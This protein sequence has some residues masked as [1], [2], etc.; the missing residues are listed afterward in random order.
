MHRTLLLICIVLTSGTSFSQSEIPRYTLSAAVLGTREVPDLFWLDLT[1]DEDGNPNPEYKQLDIGMGNRG[2]KIEV[3]ALPP[4]ALYRRSTSESGELEFT[5]AIT[6]PEQDPDDHLLVLLVRNHKGEGG[7][8]Y[9]DDSAEAHPPHMVRIANKGP[10][11]C[12][13]VINQKPKVIE[14][15]QVSLLGKPRLDER[16]RF[17][18]DFA[19]EL[20]DQSTHRDPS[21]KLRFRTPQ[22]RLLVVFSYFPVFLDNADGSSTLSHYTPISYRMYDRVFLKE[23]SAETTSD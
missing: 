20:P 3:P 2:S 12:V 6:I 14:P 9:M 19:A 23:D 5:P 21:A 18:F 16:N 7:I 22:D 11:R 8:T 4:F 17:I 13:A 1:L 10:G 15:G